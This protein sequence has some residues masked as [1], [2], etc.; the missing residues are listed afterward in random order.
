MNAKCQRLI[1]VSALTI[2][3]S[4]G[5]N[6]HSY[7]TDGA[8]YLFE[9]RKTVPDIAIKYNIFSA[10]FERAAPSMITADLG[11]GIEYDIIGA[12]GVTRKGDIDVSKVPFWIYSQHS[13][14]SVNGCKYV[15]ID[16]LTPPAYKPVN[17][18]EVVKVVENQANAAVLRD[19]GG[20]YSL[21][22]REVYGSVFDPS[23]VSPYLL[24]GDRKISSGVVDGLARDLVSRLL[25]AFGGR[26][27]VQNKISA[28][29]KELG[30]TEFSE[31]I[32]ALLRP[33]F[34]A[35]GIQL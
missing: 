5:A 6:T 18:I 3:M 28:A 21:V 16:G 32:P 12:D 2:I 22:S 33:A 9:G 11:K 31:S 23:F 34:E 29:K 15:L 4:L 24:G 26:A 7:A 8:S 10:T 13:E 14:T 17:P 19:C 20:G 27:G 30:A 1:A 25:I 35:A